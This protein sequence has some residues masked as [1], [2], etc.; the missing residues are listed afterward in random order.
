H[1]SKLLRRVLARKI[2]PADISDKQR[3]SCEHRSWLGRLVEVGHH[4]ANAFGRVPWS[5]K[6]IESGTAE[7]YG[8]A[9]LHSRVRESSAGAVAQV[10]ARAG[11]LGK[12][13]VARNEVG[14]QVGLN[15]VLDL[16]ISFPSGIKINVDVA[17]RIDDRCHTIGTEQ[18]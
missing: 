7:L 12:L 14:V 11:A 1:R 2:W 6:K 17:L 3:V 9:I 8:I 5:R 16:Q 10:D 18:I 15:D 13:V 4:N